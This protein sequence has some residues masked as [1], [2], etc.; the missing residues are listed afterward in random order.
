M[1]TKSKSQERRLLTQK[2]KTH[3]HPFSKSQKKG[4][5]KPLFFVFIFFLHDR[6]DEDPNDKIGFNCYRGIKDVHS[7]SLHCRF[8]RGIPRDKHLLVHS[9]KPVLYNIFFYP[10]Y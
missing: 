1:P 5:T 2:K 3:K 7:S 6:I 4:L 9:I 10:C 8:F